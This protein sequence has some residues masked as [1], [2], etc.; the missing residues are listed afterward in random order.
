MR[1]SFGTARV[2]RKVL[3]APAAWKPQGVRFMDEQARGHAASGRYAVRSARS[4]L[5]LVRSC[6]AKMQSFPAV[7]EHEIGSLCLSARGMLESKTSMASRSRAGQG[8]V[9]TESERSK[10]WKNN[11]GKTLAGSMYNSPYNLNPSQT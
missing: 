7:N 2:D 10:K 1:E 5:P 4:W 8:L 9:Q 3:P 11:E 6:F